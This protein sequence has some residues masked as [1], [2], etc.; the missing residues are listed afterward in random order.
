MA[1]KKKGFVSEEIFKTK[2]KEI[3]E[4]E[5]I[6]RAEELSKEYKRLLLL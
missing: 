4:S 6:S 1:K 2:P 5:L 3:N